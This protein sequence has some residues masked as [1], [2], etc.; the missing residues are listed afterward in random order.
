MIENGLLKFTFTNNKLIYILKIINNTKKVPMQE[1]NENQKR[2]NV[3]PSEEERE[4]ARRLTENPNIPEETKSEAEKK[5]EEEMKRRTEE[6]LK[7]RNRS[8]QEQEEKSM[9][10]EG[11]RSESMERQKQEAQYAQN[12]DSFEAPKNPNLVE[13]PQDPP[14]NIVPPT[15]EGGSNEGNE[16]SGQSQEESSEEDT[17]YDFIPLPSDGKIYNPKKKGL[18]VAYLDTSD[19]DILTSPNLIESGDFMR[20]ILDRKILD[21][22][23][24]YDDLHVGDKNAILIWLRA[25]AYGEEYPVRL[26]D[27]KDGQEFQ[28]TIDL[29]ELG[30]IP[31]GDEPDN[32]GNLDFTL[33][34]SK[35]NIK[36]KFLSVGEE[37]S[38]EKQ[39]D[40]EM[41]ELGY[42]IN[43]TIT[44]SMFKHIVE[45]DGTRDPNYIWQFVK[46]M[47]AGDSRALRKHIQKVE[48]GMDLNITVRTP[49]GESHTYFLSFGPQFFWPDA[50][51]Q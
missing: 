46:K 32:E 42:K 22:D 21:E 2:P 28:R 33:P 44:Y 35:K 20:V 37:E 8:L 50:E 41:N 11:N 12:P 17:P 1:E 49:G 3:I 31:L 24:R 48:P 15:D 4:E 7:Q 26:T 39:V 19:E 51:P 16:S 40:H 14:N 36:F 47:R 27:P 38:I 23:I 18:K 10:L 6:Q 25:T 13:P 5:A 43:H 45:V 29:N 9:E 30:T 34:V